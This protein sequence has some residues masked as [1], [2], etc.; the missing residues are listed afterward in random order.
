MLKSQFLPLVGPACR[1]TATTVRVTILTTGDLGRIVV[2]FRVH[3][4]M[5]PWNSLHSLIDEIGRERLGLLLGGVCSRYC[6]GTEHD[7]TE[8]LHDFGLCNN[9]INGE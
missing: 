7:S 8:H 6:D 2:R 9:T 5:N 1:A 4:Q 3:I